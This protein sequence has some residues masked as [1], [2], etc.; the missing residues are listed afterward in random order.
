[1]ARK[2]AVVKKEI[3]E[4]EILTAEDIKK[5]EEAVIVIN[6]K[7]N[8]TAKSLIEI[9]QYLLKE[10]FD[11]DI[12][13]AEDRAP[14]K[15]ISLRKIADHKDITLSFMSLSNAI[16][17]AG[18]ESLFTHE[19]Y[20]E[21]TETHKLLLFSLSDDKA[22]KSYADKVVKDKLSVRALRDTLVEK[23]FILP[24]GRTAISSEKRL[25]AGK[26]PLITFFTPLEKLADFDV[27]LFQE[28]DITQERI[29]VLESI[30]DRIEKLLAKVS[31]AD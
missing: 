5:I 29:A 8:S 3:Q 21:L 7:A 22:K 19:K 15:G 30:K 2:K 9:G 14:R 28:E 13:K 18:Q 24:R 16:R 4:V 17:L 1:M 20:K 10:F 6:E 12:K 11:N 25:T 31:K 27:D 26:D 23:G